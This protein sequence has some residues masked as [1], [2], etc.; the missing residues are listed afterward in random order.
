MIIAAPTQTNDGLASV[1]SPHYG[2]SPFFALYDTE[3]GNLEF[4]QKQAHSQHNGGGCAPVDELLAAKVKKVVC[5]GLGQGAYARLQAA[6]LQVACVDASITTLQDMAQAI[7]A[8]SL[9][10]QEHPAL[11]SHN[12][13]NGHDHGGHSHDHS[14]QGHHHS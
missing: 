7:Q 8:E 9:P 11:C 14:S 3:S 5:K 2:H 10:V 12:H 4:I 1:I 13:D 6:G